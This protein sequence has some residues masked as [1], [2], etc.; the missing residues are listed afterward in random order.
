MSDSS[1][2]SLL[3]RASGILLH[4]TSLPGPYGIGDL[5][6]AAYAWIDL[7]ARGRQSL[8]QILP[9]CPPGY[10]ASPYQGLSAFAG[11]MY[12]ISPDALVQDGLLQPGDLAGADFPAERADFVRVVEY[13]DRLFARAWHN[14]S[15]GAAPHLR[16]PLESFH[17]QEAA[18]LHDFALF[19]A[20]KNAHGGKAWYDWP[21]ELKL[22][23]QAALDAAERE[24][25]DQ[26]GFHKFL[27]F[28]FSHQWRGIREYANRKGIQV[29]GDIPIFVSADSVDVW[30][31]P[32]LFWL[33]EQRRPTHV[34]GVPPDYF[35][36]TGQLWGNPLYRWEVLAHS[37]YDWWL[38]RLNKTLEHVDIAR[39]DH[40]RGFEAYWEIPAGM[41]TAEK[42][43]WVKAPGT[44]FFGYVRSQ[45][46]L[47]PLIAE[48]LGEIT[49]EV[50]ELRDRFNLP[51]MRILQFAFGLGGAD[52]VY[53]PHNFVRNA[54][55][56]TGTHDNDTTQGWYASIQQWERDNVHRYLARDGRDIVWDLLRLAWSSVA[57]FAVAPLQD[58]LTLGG[59]ARMNTPGKAE[60]N[61]AWRVTQGQLRPEAF[62]RLREMTELYGRVAAK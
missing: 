18:C 26:I 32:E 43:H 15:A 49:P 14:F 51:G 34:A 44:E 59:E 4:P 55:V 3:R 48:D 11:N 10:G 23:E 56:Y 8:W 57:D 41:L 28:L 52:N 1:P 20:L 38:R 9:L 35:S 37:N 6:L 61:W 45:L 39:I 60:G 25:R 30:A 2:Q 29:I 24:L 19:M 5:G 40:F 62:D 22:R 31:H 12:L 50:E 27:Q 53:L 16:G 36:K 54:V 42:G 13:K 21:R 46:G 47:L 7:L 58:V 17:S 33:D